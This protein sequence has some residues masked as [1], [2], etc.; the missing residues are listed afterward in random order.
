MVIGFKEQFVQKIL[1]GEKFHTIRRDK[2]NRWKKGMIMHMATGMR[3]KKYKQF[4][5]R[6]CTGTQRIE[7]YPEKRQVAFLSATEGTSFFLDEKGIESLRLSL[8]TM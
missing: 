2:N 4:A 5:Q 6:V 7:I 1:S 8:L 3:T